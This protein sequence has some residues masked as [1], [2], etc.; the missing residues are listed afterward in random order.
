MEGAKA[1]ECLFSSLRAVCPRVLAE[2]R[3]TGGGDVTVATE[4]ALTPRPQ[5]SVSHQLRLS[6]AWTVGEEEGTPPCRRGHR[7]PP[8]PPRSAISNL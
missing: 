3:D 4:W 6:P 1:V 2:L 5:L 8:T 7:E